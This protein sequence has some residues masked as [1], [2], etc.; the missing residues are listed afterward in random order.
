MY[1]VELGSACRERIKDYDL[2]VIES[3]WGY[4]AVTAPP[5]CQAAGVP[6]VVALRGQLLPWSLSQ[7]YWK[8]W[9]CLRLFTCRALNFAAGLHCTDQGEADALAALDLRAPAFVVPNSV[10]ISGMGNLPG[11]GGLRRRLGIADTAYLLLFVGRLHH[12]K[13]PEIAVAALAAARA[14]SQDAH[15]MFVGPDE[16]DL[17]LGLKSKAIACGCIDR[18]HFA[19]LL[20]GEALLQAYVDADLLVMPSEPRS[21]NFGRSAAEGMAAGLPIL[22]SDGVPIG[23]WA[24]EAGAGRSVSCSASAF[25][26]ATVDLL[27]APSQLRR[28]GAQ[29]A[30]LAKRRF[31]RTAVATQMLEHYRSILDTGAPIVCV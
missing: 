13:R 1:S 18:L 17:S 20:R 5:A 28:M 3:V 29:G 4:V 25:G 6:Y 14:A 22:V 24:A 27:S 15:L 12:K 21:E 11:R 2:A 9:L 19:G 10:D 8:K 23:E 30:V 16:E 31:D 7:K 26:E